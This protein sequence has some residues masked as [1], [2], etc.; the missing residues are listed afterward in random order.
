[1]SVNRVSL[2]VLLHLPQLIEERQV[3]FGILECTGVRKEHATQGREERS[4]NP[5]IK[6]TSRRS[7]E[8]TTHGRE[9][10]SEK[11]SIKTTS[12]RSQEGTTHGREPLY[13]DHL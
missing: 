13:K 8:G 4:G 9:E 3:L 11:L 7:Q 10:R 6:T 12:R 1:M 5:F 2:I